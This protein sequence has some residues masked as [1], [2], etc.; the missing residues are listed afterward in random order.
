MKSMSRNIIT[1]SIV[2]LALVLW[3][4]SG[5]LMGKQIDS[6]EP[7]KRA[8]IEAEPERQAGA[9][10]RVRVSV[11]DAE[12]RTRHLVLRGRTESKR[13]VDVK[14]EIA[15]SVVSRPVERGLQV[16]QGDLLCELAVDDREV[17]LQEARAAF[18]TARIEHEG[19]LRLREQ[20]LVSEVTTAGSQ[21]RKEAAKAH[22][23]RQKLNLEKTRIVAPFAGVVEDLHLNVGD[24]A[25]S[26]TSCAT[27]IDLNPMLVRAHVTEAEVDSLVT[28]EAVSGASSVGRRM[29]GLVSFV[30][31]QSDPVTRTYP[32]EITVDN[33]DYSI[34]SGLTVTLNIG[35]E[36]VLAHKV[37][38]SLLTLNDAGVMGIRTL[39]TANRVVFSPVEILEDGAEGVWITGLPGTVSLITVGQEYVALGDIV[40]P[41][42]ISGPK[43][44]LAGL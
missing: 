19:T 14:A 25:V 37:S 29:T 30:G 18:E 42:Y 2:A 41:V 7:D 13:V 22:L 39:D 9:V 28:G 4:G 40:D 20:G 26:G 33:Q 38:P 31:K 10:T 3:M 23:H 1:A 11:I 43:D 8:R 27:L 17:A 24:Y 5:A 6:S 16:A 44:Q 21:A 32:V 12:Q 34:R 15:G 36:D 35:V